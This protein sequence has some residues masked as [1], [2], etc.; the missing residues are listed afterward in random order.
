[1]LISLEAREA[2]ALWQGAVQYGKL[3]GHQ[4]VRKGVGLRRYADR[5][6]VAL[7]KE[8]FGEEVRHGLSHTGARLDRTMG[9]TRKRVADLAGHLHL[10]G[11]YLEV[12]IETSDNPIGRE[13]FLDLQ[14]RRGREG[15]IL[16]GRVIAH[17]PLALAYEAATGE[18]EREGRHLGSSFT[19]PFVRRF[20]GEIGEYGP[21]LPVDLL[22]HGRQKVK[23]A[24]GKVHERDEHDAPHPRQGLHVRRGT[25]RRGIAAEGARHVGKAM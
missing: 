7:G 9:R 16:L 21:E 13:G 2:K 5:Q 14:A 4:L 10:I 19:C 17:V 1:M 25:M 18:L 3:V 15:L 6:V 23:Q 24:R 20:V 12:G 11:T 8:D 22:M